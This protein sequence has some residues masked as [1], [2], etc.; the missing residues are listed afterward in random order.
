MVVRINKVCS[1]KQTECRL[2]QTNAAWRESLARGGYD[3][4]RLSVIVPVKLVVDGFVDP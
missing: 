3:R 1:E 2:L 4:M